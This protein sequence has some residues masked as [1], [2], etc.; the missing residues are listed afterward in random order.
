LIGR[1]RIVKQAADP[2][3]KKIEAGFRETAGGVRAMET[4]R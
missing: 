3:T 2:S 1:I 4:S